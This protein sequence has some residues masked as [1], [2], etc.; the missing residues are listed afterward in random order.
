VS[1]FQGL[2]NLICLPWILEDKV[3]REARANV[4]EAARKKK[5]S[6][7]AHQAEYQ[8]QKRVVDVTS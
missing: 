8:Q 4:V 7:E 5:V 1:S 2:G 3:A 6:H